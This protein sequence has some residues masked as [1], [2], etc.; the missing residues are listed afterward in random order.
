MII[1]LIVLAVVV[2]SA[3]IAF[4]RGFIREVLTI[5][6]TVGGLVAAYFFGPVLSPYIQGWLGVT[7]G[8]EPGRLLGLIPYTLLGDALAY[9]S[10]FII[11]VVVLSFVSHFLA[12]SVKTLGLGAVDRSMGVVF[13]VLR[14]AALL[15]LLYMPV[16]LFV[17]KTERDVWFKG[18][19]TYFYLEATAGF[20]AEF[21]PENAAEKTE[22]KAQAIEGKAGEAQKLHEKLQQID[23]LQK[24]KP[25][26]KSGEQDK[27]K[28][29]TDEFRRKMDKL[30]EDAGDG[31]NE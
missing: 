29:Y 9:G 10:I 18:S 28:G 17:E 20:I 22:E 24:D 2:I 13:G 11:V 7:E 31:L 12:E 15:G 27:A 26:E 1:D 5:F 4:L 30:F 16:Y 19:R 21:L 6:G 3:L 8:E 14:A 23:L 25:E